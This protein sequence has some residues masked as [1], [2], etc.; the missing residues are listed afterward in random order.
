MPEFSVAVDHAID[1]RTL[2]ADHRAAI[3]DDAEAN[4][5]ADADAADAL[6]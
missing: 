1:S 6:P 5:D 4:A 3:L 2:L